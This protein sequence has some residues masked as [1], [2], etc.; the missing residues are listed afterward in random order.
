MDR[1]RDEDYCISV[2]R[3]PAARAAAEAAETLRRQHR[4]NADIVTQT[5]QAGPTGTTSQNPLGTQ[6]VQPSGGSGGSGVVQP[7]STAQ[8]NSSGANQTPSKPNALVGIS[9]TVP[10]SSH[11]YK[12]LKPFS[13]DRNKARRITTYSLLLL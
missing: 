11:R 9:N 2:I 4:D 13:H 10:H 6:G 5:V 1:L 3:D 8:Q 7:Q 12:F